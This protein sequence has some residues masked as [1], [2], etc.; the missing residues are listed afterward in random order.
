MSMTHEIVRVTLRS[1]THRYQRHPND[2]ELEQMATEICSHIDTIYSKDKSR[3][4]DQVEAAVS[5]IESSHGLTPL[6]HLYECAA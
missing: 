5:F 1:R 2:A 6:S 4:V 3:Y